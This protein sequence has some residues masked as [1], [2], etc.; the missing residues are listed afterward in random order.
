MI[1]PNYQAF[2]NLIFQEDIIMTALDL[3]GQKFGKLTVIERDFGH[4]QTGKTKK[5]YWFCQCSCENH[6][7]ISVSTTNLRSGNTKSCGC[8]KHKQ[9]P[10]LDDIKGQKFG[11]LTAIE[12]DNS[13]KATKHTYWFC[14]CD[15]GRE[16]LISVS[17]SN[18]KTGNTRSCG[19]DLRSRGESKIIDLLIKNNIPFEQQKTFETCIFPYSN[20]KARFD[21][22]IN[23]K[24]LIEYDGNIHYDDSVRGWNTK[25]KIQSQQERD[26]FKNKWCKE[27]NI[28]LIRIPYTHYDK[29]CIKDLLLETSQF[30]FQR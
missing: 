11:H 12:K 23:N 9:S 17:V 8:L 21:F 1:T 19:C 22:Y 26:N 30:I 24:Y 20:R 4:P 16:N 28:P 29:L 7:I 25:E 5:A 27:N 10:L 14:Q 15:C 6:T 18:L 3:T 13:K 2:I